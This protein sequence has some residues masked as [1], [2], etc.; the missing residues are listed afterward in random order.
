[1][2]LS[3]RHLLSRSALTLRTLPCTCQHRASST[4]TFESTETSSS[5]STSPLPP[6]SSLR[7]RTSPLYTVPPLPPLPPPLPSDAADPGAVSPASSTSVIQN[8]PAHHEQLAVLNACL[9]SGDIN[10]AEEVAKRLRFNWAKTRIGGGDKALRGLG[11]VLPPR[12]HA[13]FLRAYLASALL[14][15]KPSA[16]RSFAETLEASSTY[17]PAGVNKARYIHKAWLYFDSLLTDQWY[18]PSGPHNKKSYNQAIDATVFAVLLKGL[19]AAGPAIYNPSAL[20]DPDNW[21]RPITHLLPFLE[22]FNLTLLDV[23]SDSVFDVDLTS[24]LGRVTRED[25]L[26]VITK[27]GN[28]RSGWGE[29]QGV[30]DGV[31]EAFERKV[32]GHAEGLAN[33]AQAKD[34]DPTTAVS[35]ILRFRLFV[36]PDSNISF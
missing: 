2:L 21:Q 17:K 12:V 30:V 23:M 10:R 22:K 8:A 15:S 9:A 35:R 19:T 5:S 14:I 33:R 18:S 27:T 28:G 24:Y 36:F 3:R 34:L 20:T 31:R 7:R 25:V 4:S 32:D 13:D 29:W 6:P 26:D 16:S 11:L 1:M